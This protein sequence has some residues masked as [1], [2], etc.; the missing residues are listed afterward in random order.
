M[1]QAHA[2]DPALAAL[3]LDIVPTLQ[4]TVATLIAGALARTGAAPPDT[5]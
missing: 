2:A 5:R 4:Q 3:A 1:R